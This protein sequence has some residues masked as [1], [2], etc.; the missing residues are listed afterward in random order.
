MEI[1]EVGILRV[2]KIMKTFAK[3]EFLELSMKVI[4][5]NEYGNQH[6]RYFV[7]TNKRILLLN[8]SS[9]Q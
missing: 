3:D 6:G 7:L 8:K 9:K 2:P 5:T 1:D 4:K